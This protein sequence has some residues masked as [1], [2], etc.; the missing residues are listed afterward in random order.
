MFWKNTLIKQILS[1]LDALENRDIWRKTVIEPNTSSKIPEI[2][3]R[4]IREMELKVEEAYH[5]LDA[6]ENELAKAQ[7]TIEEKDVT[8]RAFRAQHIARVFETGTLCNTPCQHNVKLSK[9]VIPHGEYLASAVVTI[10]IDGAP[11]ECKF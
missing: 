5:R 9:I 3:L 1:R 11:Y 2:R 8:I 6:C 4:R 10:L 7:K